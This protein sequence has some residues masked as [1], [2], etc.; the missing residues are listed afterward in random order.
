MYVCMYVIRLCNSYNMNAS[1]YIWR[2]VIKETIGI[3][4]N[5]YF[6]IVKL[7]TQAC[8]MTEFLLIQNYLSSTTYALLLEYID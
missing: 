8:S 3:T 1:Q 5:I 6:K 2:A 4:W 7:L